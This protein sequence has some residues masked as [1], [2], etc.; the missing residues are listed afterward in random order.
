[1]ETCTTPRGCVG[2][3]RKAHRGRPKR[4]EADMRDQIKRKFVFPAMVGVV[5]GVAACTGGSS[6]DSVT[7]EGDVAIA[8]VK[9]PVSALGNPTDAVVTG[10]GGDLDPRDKSSPSGSE[11]TLT[12]SYTNGQGDVNHPTVSFDGTKIVF[13]MRGPIDANWSIWEYDTVGN[14]MRRIACDAAFAGDDTE[15]AYLPDGRIVFVSN[16]QETTKRQMQAQGIALGHAGRG[17]ARNHRPQELLRHRPARQQRAGQSAGPAQGPVLGV[18]I[19]VPRRPDGAARRHA[20][21]GRV[22]ARA[23][24]QP[25]PALGRHQPGTRGIYP[26]AAAGRNGSDGQPHDRRG[27]AAVRHLHARPDFQDLAAGRSAAER[28]LLRESGSF[29]GAP[30]TRGDRPVHARRDHP[31]RIGSVRRPYRLRHRR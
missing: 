29:A 1:M 5:A 18:R 23:V 9:R 26:F 10:Q 22:A 30:Q 11:T 15:P 12:G 17:V 31:R 8:Y 3:H 6:S 24:P 20:R 16:R 21:Q 27:N 14:A 7:V 25:V 13:A 2:S 19:A 28:L 4:K